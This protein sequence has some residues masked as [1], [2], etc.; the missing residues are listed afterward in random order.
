MAELRTQ[1]APTAEA[2]RLA[3]ELERAH[4]GGAWHGPSLIETLVDV[5][6]ATALRRPIAA[7][8]TIWEIV[9]HVSGWLDTCRRRIEDETDRDPTPEQDWPPTGEAVEAGET[10]EAAWQT[11]LATLDDRFRRFH[12]T[13]AAL[14]DTHLEAPVTGSAPT[15]RGLVLG[16]IQHHAYHGGQ[17]TLLRKSGVTR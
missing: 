9:S 4:R 14:D 17:I 12:A 7:A 16:V 10:A 1:P 3:D 8:H 2:A 15:V 5:D 11:E 13:V 6:A